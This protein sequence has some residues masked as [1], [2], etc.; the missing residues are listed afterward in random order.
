MERLPAL[1]GGEDY[2]AD[3]A[4]VCPV[5]S[6]HLENRRIACLNVEGLAS[7]VHRL[8]LSS[9]R[10]DRIPDHFASEAE[11]LSFEV[12]LREIWANAR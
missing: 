3:L 11:R 12:D 7:L 9:T 8:S 5:A 2:L 6:E 4:V 1:R 10:L